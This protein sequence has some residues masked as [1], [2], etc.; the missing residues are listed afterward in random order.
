MFRSSGQSSTG[1][2]EACVTEQIWTPAYTAGHRDQPVV[3]LFL[4]KVKRNDCE[5]FHLR[6]NRDSESRIGRLDQKEVRASHGVRVG[7]NINVGAFGGFQ[8]AQCIENIRARAHTHTKPG[9]RNYTPLP[10]DPRF[11]ATGVIVIPNKPAIL[12]QSS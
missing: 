2:A 1:G 11:T 8:W 6:A 4:S 9:L 10:N 5:S 12:A 3:R 7:P